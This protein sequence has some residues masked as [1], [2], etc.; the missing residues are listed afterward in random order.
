MLGL[1]AEWGWGMSIFKSLSGS[2]VHVR[3]RGAKQALTL[4]QPVSLCQMAATP[5]RASAYKNLFG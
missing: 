2:R 5:T 3:E 4:N 1:L